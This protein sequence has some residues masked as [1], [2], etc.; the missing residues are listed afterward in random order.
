M[1]TCSGFEN[2]VVDANICASV[3]LDQVLSGKH[4]NRALRIHQLLLDAVERLT[5]Q[6]FLASTSSDVSDVRYFSH[7]SIAFMMATSCG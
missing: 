1:V 3:S 2:I 7:S 5:L 4:Y 6:E